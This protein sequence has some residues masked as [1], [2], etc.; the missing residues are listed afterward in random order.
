MENIKKI[1]LI[2]EIDFL[3]S[4][5]WKILDSE[6]LEMFRN[7]A[8]VQLAVRPKKFGK[9]TFWQKNFLTP[10]PLRGVPRRPQN[11]LGFSGDTGDWP[12]SPDRGII[13]FKDRFSR[14]KEPF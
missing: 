7:R 5:F 6:K 8:I 13:G 14:I 9:L 1:F 11:P 4:D 12:L 10:P 3:N 2:A